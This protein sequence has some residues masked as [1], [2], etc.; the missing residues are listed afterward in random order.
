MN[1]KDYEKF[2]LDY[3]PFEWEERDLEK[4]KRSKHSFIKTIRNLFR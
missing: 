1:Y 3:T 4:T 2:V